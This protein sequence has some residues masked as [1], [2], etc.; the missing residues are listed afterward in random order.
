MSP[1]G[2]REAA[3]GGTLVVARDAEFE[4]LR[5]I[6][7]GDTIHQWASRQ[8][9]A[10]ALQGRGVAWATRL[11]TGAEV[12]VRHSQHGGILAPLTGDIFLAPSRAPDELY[13]AVR[14][15]EAGIPTPEVVAYAVYSAIGPFCRADVVTAFVDGVDFPA[16]WAAALGS[17]ARDAIIDAV[18]ALLRVMQ[19]AGAR[20]PDLNVKNVLISQRDGAPRALLLDVDRVHFMRV[21]L[22]SVDFVRSGHEMLGV[23]NARR[24]MASV[25]KWRG[26]HGLGV[27]D[28]HWNRLMD[29]AG[30]T[31]DLL[32]MR[33]AE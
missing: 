5:E 8:P 11:A 32:R 15:R 27:S 3:V 23:A 25:M 20:H 16:A 26:A 13:A 1:T 22:H 9:G 28:A 31:S 12:V 18:A 33:R 4:A 30:V 19:A 2:Y 10:R 21:D 6:V 29:G 24:L 14:L 17:E 7:A